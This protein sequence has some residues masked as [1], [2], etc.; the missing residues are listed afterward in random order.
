MPEAFFDLSAEDR[1]E[2][3]RLAESQLGRTANLLEK[4]IYVVWV[5]EKIFS[6]PIGEH[7]TFKGGTSLS[8]AYNL[9]NRFSEDVDLT[10]DIRQ[11]VPEL[12]AGR[13]Y[14]ESSAEAK[15]WRKEIDKQ[16]PAWIGDHVVPVLTAALQHDGVEAE[17]VQETDKLY[18]R[19][20]SQVGESD[21]V[22]PA[23]LLEFGARSSGSPSQVH[24]VACDAAQAIPEITFPQAQPAVLDVN[25][26]FWEKATAAHVYCA[27]Q[28][29][30]S[31]RFARHWHDLAAIG[32]SSYF[33]GAAG[34]AVANAVA[35]HK[36]WFFKEKDV[37]G[38]EIDYF[39]AVRQGLQIVPT[40][41]ARDALEH[42][43]NQMVEG[44]MLMPGHLGFDELMQTC[45]ELEA[46]LNATAR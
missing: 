5:L 43:Y 3:I 25:R 34:D 22:R 20:P 24:T 12:T 13:E 36:S 23:V 35:Q 38:I 7:L 27:Q 41:P 15:R 19:Y 40:G 18:L 21:Y 28:R 30:R 17:L 29:L 46:V 2:A 42:D 16:L 6:N 10:Y 37:A 11:L 8:K 44:G 26:T 9:I 33:A 14:P 1:A 31:D 45:A 32:Q 4:D 39:A